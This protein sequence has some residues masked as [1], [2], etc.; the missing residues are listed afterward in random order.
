M[1][2]GILIVAVANA[3]YGRLA[4][5]L[6][7]TI[8]AADP[9]FPVAV[10]TGG[11]VALSHLDNGQKKVFDKIIH[12][13][14]AD[15][16]KAGAKLLSY[17]HTPFEA[18]LVIDADNLWM[19]EH[20]PSDVFQALKGKKF[21]GITEGW[22]DQDGKDNR[23]NEHYPMWANYKEI[24][25]AYKLGSGRMYQW[26]TEVFYF[27]KSAATAALF[28]KALEVYRKPKV[29]FMV[30]D[31]GMP[32]ELALNIAAAITKTEPHVF[33]W[34]PTYWHQKHGGRVLP[35]QI[36]TKDHFIFSGGGN[37]APPSVQKM[38]N[39]IASTAHRKLGLQF[40]FTL[41]SKRNSLSGRQK[42]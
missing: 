38:Y 8:K 7:V 31:G 11:D 37:F 29:P 14:E 13:P 41:Q 9:K 20:Q 23:L 12:V 5:N 1:K 17:D 40:L 15:E 28:K 18:T 6:A 21:A 4:Y 35:L 27:E 32:D 34:Q 16:M 24:K 42:M 22:I 36:I 3:M 25:K 30:W 39:S 26:R 33:N 10:L 2:Q 19:K